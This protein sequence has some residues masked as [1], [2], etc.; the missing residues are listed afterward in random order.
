LVE[1]QAP[2]TKFKVTITLGSCVPGVNILPTVV[3]NP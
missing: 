1:V 3:P 2:V